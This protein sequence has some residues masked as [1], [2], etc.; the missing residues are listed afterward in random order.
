MSK[1]VIVIGEA[2]REFKKEF[3]LGIEG[4]VKASA[5][6]VQAIDSHP[7]NADKFKQ[8]C[9]DLI[10]SSAWAN[11]EAVGRK[12]IHPRML[13]GGVND[14]KKRVLI[15][16]LPYSLQDRVFKRERFPLLTDKGETLEIDILEATPEQAEQIIDGAQIRP[17]SAQKAWKEAKQGE[18]EK[19][20]IE[21]LPFTIADGKISFR[22]GT[23]LTRAE[24]KRIIA[25]M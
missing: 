16:H 15:K 11:F 2:I 19:E 4:I 8:A 17:L 12:H 1:D 14:P 13:F 18:P 10:P 3:A 5:I 20:K 23:V 25:E 22:R 21:V 24:L 9:E 6:Y 7:G